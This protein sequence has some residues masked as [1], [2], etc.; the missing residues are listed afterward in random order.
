MIKQK[1]ILSL[2]GLRRDLVKTSFEATCLEEKN[3]FKVG[4]GCKDGKE[5]KK[6]RRRKSQS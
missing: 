3:Y 6:K 2:K 5:K 1:N 4:E